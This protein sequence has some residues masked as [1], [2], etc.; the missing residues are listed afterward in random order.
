MAKKCPTCG[1]DVEC[2]ADCQTGVIVGKRADN[3]PIIKYTPVHIPGG[4]DCLRRQIASLVA[5]VARLT[6]Q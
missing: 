4:M 1:E 3:M 2:L 5:E 6:E